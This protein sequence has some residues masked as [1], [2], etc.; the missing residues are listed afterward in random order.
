MV[1]LPPTVDQLKQLYYKKGDAALVWCAWRHALRV[2]PW[3]FHESFKSLNTDIRVQRQY[4]LVRILILLAQW[5]LDSPNIKIALRKA[6]TDFLRIHANSTNSDIK[7]LFEVATVLDCALSL[8]AAVY[9]DTPA[10]LC[11]DAYFSAAKISIY[12]RKN[13]YLKHMP[14]AYMAAA[15][16]ADFLYMNNYLGSR[17]LDESVWLNPELWPE[18]LHNSNQPEE[19]LKQST[20]LLEELHELNLSFLA[21]DLDSLWKSKSLA[22]Y[23]K[24]Y[25]ENLSD[26][27][28]GNPKFLKRAILYGETT[29]HIQAVRV[30]LLGAG[31]AGKTSLAKLL[32]GEKPSDSNSTIT[33]GVDYQKNQSIKLHETLPELALEESDLQLYL[34]D[35]AGQ[36]IF[37]GLHR[38]FLHENC[39]YIL[40]VD[41]R[42]EQAPEDWLYQ[43]RYLAGAKAKVLLVTNEYENCRTR[44]N[45]TKLLRNFND[46][47]EKDRFFYFSCI[48]PDSNIFKY[49]V[50]KLLQISLD[51]RK[52]VF[53]STL[54]VQQLLTK[55]YEERV[56]LSKTR[57]AEI[58]DE[59]GQDLEDALAHHQQLGF[60]ALVRRGS[61]QYCL[62]PSWIVDYAYKILYSDLVRSKDGVATIDEL[63][64]VLGKSIE[65]EDIGYL[66]DFLNDRSLCC[67][68]S[69]NKYFFPDIAQANE[70]ESVEELLKNS[71]NVPLRFDLPYFPLGFHSRLV[72]RL[73]NEVDPRI[74]STDSIWRHGFILSSLNLNAHAI[75]EYNIRKTYIKVIFAD[76]V[77][78]FGGLFNSLYKA[79]LSIV[80]SISDINPDHIHLSLLSNEHSLPI[81]S[82]AEFIMALRS[83]RSINNLRSIFSETTGKK[84]SVQVGDNSQVIIDAQNVAQNYSV[85]NKGEKISYEQGRY[86]D[87]LMRE[88][89]KTPCSGQEI[90]A[91]G[92]VKKALDD[93]ESIQAKG[94]LSKVLT[95]IKKAHISVSE[96]DASII[97]VSIKYKDVIISI[98]MSAAL[99]FGLM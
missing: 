65:P 82:N 70:P 66:V 11:N 92:V 34:W 10:N 19:F 78:G 7:I 23:S 59:H 46:L 31:G 69:D 76:N 8:G 45:E 88:L 12:T 43:I 27:I 16:K 49:F 20:Q 56:F 21:T 87:L 77:E 47:I 26:T 48:N 53:S 28:I 1:E 25:L 96:K 60:L 24:N 38:A 14:S 13:D 55:K 57:V 72:H 42:H 74:V 58:I 64:Q 94:F 2:A 15:A 63:E 61:S 98:I 5:P 95:E 67:L 18:S 40:V 33:L 4:I 91:I 41:S 44:Q 54:R 29:S 32:K 81:S 71:L 83:V 97:E 51:S 89:I 9:K 73:F 79:L 52:A 84:I 62:K 86:L 6:K 75:I 68:L 35:F 50:T 93:S 30:V 22:S 80:T 36:T 3:W 17:P 85:N 99:H 90:I 37:Y 39:I